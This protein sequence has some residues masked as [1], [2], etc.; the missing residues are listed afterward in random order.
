[1]WWSGNYKFICKTNST[2]TGPDC[3]LTE[4]Y[5]DSVCKYTFPSSHCV[6]V[7]WADTLFQVD[8]DQ[9][10]I[11]NELGI[12]LQPRGKYVTRLVLS[13]SIARNSSRDRYQS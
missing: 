6:P 9:M 12:G 2:L 4:G 3:R 11:S 13:S 7:G 5:P 1:M 10:L 8:S